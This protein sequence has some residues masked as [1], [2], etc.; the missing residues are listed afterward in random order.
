MMTPTQAPGWATQAFSA[1][2]FL[3]NGSSKVPVTHL[4][5]LYAPSSPSGG[6]EQSTLDDGWLRVKGTADAIKLHFHYLSSTAD[7]LH[8]E[9]ALGSD[10]ERKL[11]ASRNGYLGLYKH[12][13]VEGFWKVEPL[14]CQGNELRCRIRDH[15]GQQVK[16]ETGSGYLTVGNGAE[17]QWLIVRA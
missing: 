8:Y 1:T 13:S 15:L 12:A 4:D 14:A 2:L 9:L 5:T 11:G 7:R 10:R 3:L 16:V 6:S 17:Q